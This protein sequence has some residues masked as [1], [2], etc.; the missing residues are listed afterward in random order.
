MV[1][2]VLL[3][4]ALAAQ[5]GPPTLKLPAGPHPLRQSVE[6]TIRPDQETVSGRTDIEIEL[7]QATSL[8]WLNGEE[9]TV[10][11]AS[12]RDGAD[13]VAVRA[14]ASGQEFLGFTLARA[15]G[16]GRVVLTVA[17]DGKLNRT[18]TQGLFAQ[19]EANDW[20][21]FSQFE[22]IDARRAFPSFDEPSYKIP[23]TVT[24][25]VPGPL[26]ALSNTPEVESRAL[27]DGLKAVRFAETPPMPA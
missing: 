18:D 21:A 26:V 13:T 5:P 17:Y 2:S 6:L 7:P 22:S 19:K 4:A 15:A 11:E 23:W 14:E 16:P 8:L 3:L 20:Y 25:R 9:L 1:L 12:L 24:L 27:P 10:R